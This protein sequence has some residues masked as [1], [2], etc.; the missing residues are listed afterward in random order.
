M[1]FFFF[2]SLT[3]MSE[4]GNVFFF[5][6]ENKSIDQNIREKYFPFL[7]THNKI[8]RSFVSFLVSSLLV[9]SFTTR[10][11]FSSFFLFH[12]YTFGNVVFFFLCSFSHF[13]QCVCVCGGVLLLSFLL[14]SLFNDLRLF[15]RFVTTSELVLLYFSFFFFFLFFPLLFQVLLISLVHR[16]IHLHRR[17][18]G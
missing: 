16:V 1:S 9:S 15:F 3:A 12:S 5:F 7:F 10:A 13:I 8:G 4:E 17:T 18:F 2:R 11:M 14:S 6:L